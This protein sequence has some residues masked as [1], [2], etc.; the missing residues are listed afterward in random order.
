MKAEKARLRGFPYVM[1]NLFLADNLKN[2]NIVHKNNS[3]DLELIA[4]VSR[5]HENCRE[6]ILSVFDL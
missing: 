4:F 5:S 1:N 2:Q 6:N 3:K